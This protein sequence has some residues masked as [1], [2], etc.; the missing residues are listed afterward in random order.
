MRQRIFEGRYPINALLP[1]E[2][3]LC[4]EFQTSRHTAREALRRLAQVGLIERRQGSGSRVISDAPKEHYVHEMRSLDQLFAYATDTR[5]RVLGVGPGIPDQ[6]AEL[7]TDRGWLHL[8]ALRFD[9]DS[10]TPICFS[11]VYID[12]RFKSLRDRLRTNQDAIYRMVEDEFAVRVE[13]VVQFIHVVR[14]PTRAADA[15]DLAEDSWSAR[16]M[17]KYFEMDG[18]IIL[19]SVNFHPVEN[20]SYQMRLTRQTNA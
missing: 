19:A 16:I 17:R 11:D 13:E 6:V 3:E 1:T 10:D 7:P 8:E 2:V 20:F 18:R 5:L 14:L 9:K 4:E 12:G 15:M